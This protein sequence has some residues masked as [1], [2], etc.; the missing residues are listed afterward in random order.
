MTRLDPEPPH[1]SLELL[2]RVRGT[3]SSGGAKQWQASSLRGPR[4]PDFHSGRL[5]RYATNRD[6]GRYGLSGR[7]VTGG[8]LDE[9]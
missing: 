7:L 3:R 5:L 2:A 4:K 6:D 8:G 9:R 1:E